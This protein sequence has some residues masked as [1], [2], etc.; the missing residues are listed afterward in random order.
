MI[1]PASRAIMCGATALQ[2]WNTPSTLTRNTLRKSS[3][4][5]SAIVP[6]GLMPALFTM[7]SIA[8]QRLHAAV[9]RALDLRVVADVALDHD[10][11]TAGR[12]HHARGL[13]GF[14]SR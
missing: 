11:A 5:V 4:L 10:A 9:H 14:A 7:M 6:M 3:R 13:F 12:P 8:P 2:P 1:L